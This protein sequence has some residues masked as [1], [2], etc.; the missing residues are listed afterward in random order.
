MKI[1]FCSD[2]V[3]WEQEIKNYFPEKIIIRQKIDHVKKFDNNLGWVNNVFTSEEST[4]EGLI[5][6][7]LLSKTNFLHYNP[8]S[9]FAKL[10]KY[11]QYEL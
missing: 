7:Y 11:L 10:S 2:N 6:I 4:I 9:T 8:D 1:L 3:E 5:D